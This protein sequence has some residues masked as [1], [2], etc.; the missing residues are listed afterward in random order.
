MRR[1]IAALLVALPMVGCTTGP[2][3]SPA[4]SAAPTAAVSPS[5]ATPTAAPTAAPTPSAAPEP[6][7]DPLIGEIRAA[8]AATIAENTVTYE[9]TAEF[10]GSAVIRDGTT[11]SAT[12]ATSFGEPRQMTIRGDFTDLGLGKLRM[13][14]DGD[15]LY[16][17]GAVV[18]TLVDP[19]Q[20]LLVDLSSDDPRAVPFLS[21]TSGQ[22]DS[23]LTM[24]FLYGATGPVEVLPDDTIHGQ[25]ATRYRTA[26]DLD[27]AAEQ[28]PEEARESLLDNIAA[29][30]TGGVERTLEADVWIGE[31]GLIHR[32]DY[33]YTV[34]RVAGG[35][36]MDVTN[37]FDDFGAPLDLGIP[38]DE[39][40]VN[41]EDL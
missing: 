5:P 6:T 9:Q 30:R 24:Y 25:T 40:V 29:L 10:N 1:S 20:W 19:G 2:T 38:D 14:L 21:L 39:D 28:V 4:V 15:L 8:A 33:L 37:V 41:L 31:D 3:P 7:G 34:G 36:T 16:M 11:F 23:S 13:I 12:G 35:G 18:E 17:R 27:L 26:V 22:N 32:V